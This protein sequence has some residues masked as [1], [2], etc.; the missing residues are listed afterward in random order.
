MVYEKSL[1]DS[2]LKFDMFEML[3]LSFDCDHQSSLQVTP[4]SLKGI[5]GDVLNHSFYP[6]SELCQIFWHWGGVH[7]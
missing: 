5:R 4:D 1:I 3:A 2:D 6:S 7:F